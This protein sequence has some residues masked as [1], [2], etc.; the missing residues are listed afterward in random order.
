MSH[1]RA[2]NSMGADVKV[3][4]YRLE[5]WARWSRDHVP[6]QLASR[7]TI[8]RLMDEGP[9]AGSATHIVLDMPEAILE[10]DKA[11]AHLTG[12]DRTV[13]RIYY[14]RWEPVKE[15]ASRA[16]MTERRFTSVLNRARWRLSG[17]LAAA[18]Q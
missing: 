12:D 9:G 16:R 15:L 4:H 18:A 8:G 3:I 14:L 17:Y 13:I 10:M 7:N 6:G 11:I 1:S 5:A 2:V